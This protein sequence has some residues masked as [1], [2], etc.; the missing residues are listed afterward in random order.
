MYRRSARY[1]L[2]LILGFT[3]LASQIIILRQ[4]MVVFGGNELTLGL[5]LASWMIW[6]G[7]ANLIIG[8]YSDRIKRIDLVVPIVAT[9]LAV[10][11]PA[12]LV[13][14]SLIKPILGIPRAEMADLATIFLV[15]ISVL[16][17]LCFIDGMFLNLLAKTGGRNSSVDIGEVY[18]FDALGA[19]LGGIVFGWIAIE[20]LNPFLAMCILGLLLLIGV[21][22]VTPGKLLLLPKF[23]F[24][25]IVVAAIFSPQIIRGITRVNW[26]GFNPIVDIDTK[27][28]NLVVTDNHGEYTV[29]TDGLPFFTIPDK[30]TNETLAHLSMIETENPKRILVIGGGISGLSAELNKYKPEKIM[31]IQIDPEVTKLETEVMGGKIPENVEVLHEDGRYF[32]NNYDPSARE[33]YDVIILNSGDPVN[34]ATNRYF[35]KELFEA[36]KKALTNNGVLFFGVYQT[37]N[38]ISNEALEL[39]SII[40]NTL[41][42][43]YPAARIVPLDKYYFI[44]SANNGIMTN[45]IDELMNRIEMKKIPT[46]IFGVETLFGTN[47]F[48]VNQDVSL[49][50]KQA[51]KATRINT[52]NKP[53]AYFNNLMIWG[54]K[55]GLDTGKIFQHLSQLQY[56][57]VIVAFVI[58]GILSLLFVQKSPGLPIFWAL[59]ATGWTGITIELL[60]LIKYQVEIGMLFYKVGFIITAYMVGLSL[61]AFLIIQGLKRYK[62]SPTTLT[63]MMGL[64]IIYI[65]SAL[66][67]TEMSFIL[68]NFII[69]LIGGAIYQIAAEAMIERGVGKT[70]GLINGAD[71][72]GAAAGSLISAGILIPLFGFNVTLIISAT[73]VTIAII[74][75]LMTRRPPLGVK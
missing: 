14:T 12:T 73:I 23:V 72:I 43:V 41:K 47:Q 9:G 33:K 11:F 53:T 17:P 69:G 49:I 54:Q 8:R 60:I 52:D 70:A 42:S 2:F 59:F 64:L 27:Y 20:Y 67:V 40:L 3:T 46:D 25:G 56:K 48:R 71:Y 68:A 55:F 37:A 31:Y 13:I 63:I 44:A 1:A 15:T 57:W 16:G 75:N 74:I 62:P 32:L 38:Y 39:L 7:A 10:I 6:A 22:F 26:E 30:P 45:N 5:A 18:L 28:Q 29:F 24:I 50:E 66:Y 21:L 35:T 61:G 4:L 65:P 19:A 58:L 36:A 34:T 51:A